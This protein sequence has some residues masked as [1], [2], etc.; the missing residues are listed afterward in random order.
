MAVLL[1]IW[2]ASVD[3]GTLWC[4]VVVSRWTSAIGLDA[5]TK[6]LGFF[7]LRTVVEMMPG[8]TV[9][10]HRL[11]PLVGGGVPPRVAGWT[12][13]LLAAGDGR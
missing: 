2:L 6:P 4:V 11:N 8:F 12:G 10:P 5:V 13:S 1:T 3:L 9:T 7:R